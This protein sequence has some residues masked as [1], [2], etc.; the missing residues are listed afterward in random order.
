MRITPNEVSCQTDEAYSRNRRSGIL[1]GL[2][3]DEW[4]HP[5]FLQNLTHLHHT[6]TNK[7]YRSGAICHSAAFMLLWV[8]L[9]GTAASGDTAGQQSSGGAADFQAQ[10]GGVATAWGGPGIRLG[11]AVIMAL[12]NNR[13]LSVQRLNPGIQRTFE[14]RERALFDPSLSGSFYIE[15]QRAGELTASTSTTDNVGGSLGVKEVLPTGTQ[16]GLSLQTAQEETD[17]SQRSYATKA[18]ISATQAL[19]R[20]RPIAVNLVNLRKAR[21]DTDISQYELRGYAEMLVADVES[22]Y[23]ECSLARLQAEIFQ[24]SLNLA[25]KQLKEVEH[26]IRVGELPETELAAAQAEIALRREA[27]INARS[28]LSKARLQLLRLIDPGALTGSKRA[29]ILATDPAVPEIKLEALESHVAL[30][31]RMRPDL[32]QARLKIQKGE[33]D[34]VKTRNGLLPK[35]DLFVKLGKTAYA[36]SFGD[37][38]NDSDDHDYDISAGVTLEIPLG[39]RDARSSHRR[40]LLTQAQTKE[41]LENMIDLVRVDVESGYIEVERTSEQVAATAITRRLQE[42]KLRAET[43][44]F[45]VGRSTTLLVAQAQRDLVASRVSEVNAVVR[46]LQALVA[47]FRLEGTLLDQRGLSVSDQ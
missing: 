8:F 38:V 39:N 29:M 44:K 40:A 16:L 13:A 18:E 27:L 23:W 30:A 10:T 6:S 28:G 11:Q 33:L 9:A 5:V 24:E 3:D 36:A 42:E 12:T 14:D 35:L 31:L 20:G 21:I 26:R 22:S 7:V 41:A 47:L 4:R 25:E 43:A 1:T 45:N 34:L 37:T 32:N 15:R 46:H 19:L 2:Q 17:G